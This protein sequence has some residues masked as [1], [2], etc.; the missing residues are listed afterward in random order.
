MKLKELLIIVGLS[1]ALGLPLG[2]RMA[3]KYEKTTYAHGLAYF[4]PHPPANVSTTPTAPAIA[5]EWATIAGKIFPYILAYP[6][7]LNLKQFSN[8]PNDSIGIEV[9]QK[10]AVQNLILFVEKIEVVPKKFV[11]NYWQLYSG[12]AGLKNLK[13]ITN[14]QGLNGFEAS[15]TY[16]GTSG[17]SLDIFFVIPK[18]AQHL[19]H[20]MKG[21]LDENLFREIV[22]KFNFK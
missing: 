2:R 3:K 22:S 5:G 21:N 20:L 16:K 6:K 15:Y 10:P 4:G 13:E 11:E 8:D 7:N 9:E 14:P 19:I 17:Q 12:L 1:L 18:D